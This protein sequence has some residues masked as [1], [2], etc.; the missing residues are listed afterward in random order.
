MP[1]LFDQTNQLAFICHELGMTRG[2]LLAEEG[3]GARALVKNNAKPRPGCV[4][5]D[6]EGPVERVQ[7][8]HRHAGQRVLQSM[9][10]PGGLLIPPEPLLA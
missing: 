5:L 6:D 9:E 7:L 3:D 10:R 2:D 1:D 4:A 8:E